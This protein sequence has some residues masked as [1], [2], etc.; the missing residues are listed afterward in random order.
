MNK[1]ALNRAIKCLRPQGVFLIKS[2]FTIRDDIV[3]PTI[4]EADWTSQHAVKHAEDFFTAEAVDSHGDTINLVGYRLLYA[5]R[6]LKKSDIENIPAEI[7]VEDKR[8]LSSLVAAYTAMYEKAA[9]I[10]DEALREF[11]RCN[12][13]YHVTPFWRAHVQE[14]YGKAG[15]PLPIVPFLKLPSIEEAKSD[16]K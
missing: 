10:D 16:E 7:D 3:P 8:I 1:D 14:L 13:A 4:G 9:E 15:M 2:D 12:A 5:T 6:Q 11:G